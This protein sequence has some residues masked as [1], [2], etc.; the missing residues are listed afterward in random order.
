MN[1]PSISS[2][3]ARVGKLLLWAHGEEEMEFPLWLS[4]LRTW[5]CHCCCLGCYCGAGS[6]PGLG[7]SV[8]SGQS[9]NGKKKKKKEEEEEI[10]CERHKLH[11]VT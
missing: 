2:A 9:Q 10:D 7:I 1:L 8:C 6:I 5:W 11:I 3:S 4:R